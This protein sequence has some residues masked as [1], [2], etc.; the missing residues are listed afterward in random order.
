MTAPLAVACAAGI[1]YGE[2]VIVALFAAAALFLCTAL[3]AVGLFILCFSLA[4]RRAWRPP[5]VLMVIAV[6]GAGMVVGAVS[7]NHLVQDRAVLHAKAY[8]ERVA[9]QLESYRQAHGNYPQSLDQ[10]PAAPRL[11]RLL[12]DRA[13][14]SDGRSYSFQFPSPGGFIDVWVYSS[15][16]RSWHLST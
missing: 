1:W 7:L 16:T 10:L 9:P 12:R 15:E 14:S 8:P 13:Y 2:P 6:V 3:L 4:T 5:V 11:P